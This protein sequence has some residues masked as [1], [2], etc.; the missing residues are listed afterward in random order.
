MLSI[1]PTTS[2]AHLPSER[3]R[4]R[5][6]NSHSQNTCIMMP[7]F[8]DGQGVIFL[9]HFVNARKKKSIFREEPTEADG[10][11]NNVTSLAERELRTG[12]HYQRTL[13]ILRVTGPAHCSSFLLAFRGFPFSP[14]LLRQPRTAL[15]RDESIYFYGAYDARVHNVRCSS[16]IRLRRACGVC[17]ILSDESTHCFAFCQEFNSSDVCRS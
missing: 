17:I 4:K 13:A 3:K 11:R 8:D 15:S 10:P 6:P 16:L 1:I 2:E 14:S 12:P 7:W 9:R 5:I